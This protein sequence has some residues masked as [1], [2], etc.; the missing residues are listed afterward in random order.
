MTEPIGHSV[1]CQC[2]VR[3]VQ[4]G[5]HGRRGEAGRGAFDEALAMPKPSRLAP[6]PARARSSA[7]MAVRGIRRSGSP[8]RRQPGWTVRRARSANRRATW[9]TWHLAALPDD[10]DATA[11]EAD[12]RPEP[13]ADESIGDGLPMQIRA[14]QTISAI[15]TLS[16][17][18]APAPARQAKQ[19][20]L[21][22]AA[23]PIPPCQPR[24]RPTRGK[25]PLAQHAA[26]HDRTGSHTAPTPLRADAQ[27]SRT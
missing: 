2:R 25:P 7:P 21:R 3:A 1:S 13:E 17:Q 27:A 10:V 11:D 24:S 9:T 26:E 16:R 23:R 20:T 4:A 6:M 18:I 5:S 15:M 12:A 19:P 14:E 22:A 8:A